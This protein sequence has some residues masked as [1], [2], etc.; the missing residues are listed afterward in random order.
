MTT[1]QLFFLLTHDIADV[2]QSVEFPITLTSRDNYAVT[3]ADAY[4]ICGISKKFPM[5]HNDV[6]TTQLFFTD[7][8]LE[9]GQ[10]RKY[11][12]AW[13]HWWSET[14]LGLGLV[15]QFLVVPPHR[16]VPVAHAKLG[17]HVAE[18]D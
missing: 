13:R 17:L 4:A 2:M 1:T 9:S 12:D 16:E 10:K 6:T 7:A 5:T 14:R 18:V 8:G 11:K 15:R 3:F